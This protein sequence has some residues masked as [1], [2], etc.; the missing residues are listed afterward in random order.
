MRI[1][2]PAPD[3][4]CRA[5][6]AAGATVHVMQAFGNYQGTSWARVTYQ[7]RDGWVCYSWGSCSGCDDYQNTFGYGFGMSGYVDRDLTPEEEARLADFGRSY[8]DNLL[9]QS[10]AEAK[11]AE[12][13]S[14]DCESEKVV[15]FIRTNPIPTT[16]KDKGGFNGQ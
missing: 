10:E 15:A 14:W 9:T 4:Y 1:N 6:V 12:D 13:I 5:M 8:L 3:D 2:D 11:A 16:P 7:G